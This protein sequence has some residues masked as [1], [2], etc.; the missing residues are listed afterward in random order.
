MCGIAG[1]AALDARP[2][3]RI[4][5]RLAAQDRLIRHR[6]KDSAGTWVS[7]DQ[8]VGFAHRRLAIIDLDAAA[9]SR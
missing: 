5:A 8:S 1:L 4:A 9:G 2:V 7:D 6:G 3:P